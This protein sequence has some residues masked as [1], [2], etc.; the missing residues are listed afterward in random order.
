MASKVKGRTTREFQSPADVWGILDGWA[1][2]VG[3]DLV[4]QDQVSRT[5]K[6][7]T[8][9]WILPQKLNMAFTG[10]FYRM[11]AWVWLPPYY[12]FLTLFLMPTELRIES[13]GFV[14]V[15]PRNKAREQV[16]A[17]LQALGQPPI[18]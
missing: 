2:Q 18:P 12:R 13:G 14:A 8:G 9:F 17:L 3:Y 16:S 15:L 10:E 6:R 1:A 5:Y 7:G 4:E 11:E